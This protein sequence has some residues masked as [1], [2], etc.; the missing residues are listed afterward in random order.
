[1][2][3]HGKWN[4][5]TEKSRLSASYVTSLIGFS[6]VVFLNDY[7]HDHLRI[8]VGLWLTLLCVPLYIL[9]LRGQLNDA[10]EKAQAASKAKS[11]FLSNM[12][13]E[14]RTPLNGVI[15]ASDL[16]I[17]TRLDDEQ[18]DLVSTLKK[19]AQLLLKLIDNILDL[20]KIESGKLV[21]EK[22]DF[23]LHKLV[24][25]TLD[26]FLSQVEKKKI[27]LA[28][29][30]TPET[31]FQLQ[32]DPLHL[33]QVL[34]NLI[35]NAIKFTD[36][37]SVELR[38][39]T[40][41]QDASYTKLRFEVIDT[42]IGISPQAQGRIFESFTQADQNITRTY[43]GTGFGTTISKQLVELMGGEM[44]V[45]SEA[46]NWQHFLV[47]SPFLQETAYSTW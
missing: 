45:Q 14:M 2:G 41:H 25:S 29:R 10:L 44:G 4:P 6:T 34:I 18:K 32:G 24:N 31:C 47:R 5:V 28:V 12:S 40:L 39:G 21:S 42:G 15:G 3:H 46:G 19:S 27:G 38:I 20:S 33:Q 17:S 13:H 36:K 9:K 22:I 35:G 23:D 7:W 8:A 16:L 11:D 26:M 43:G 1:M 37:G 30:F